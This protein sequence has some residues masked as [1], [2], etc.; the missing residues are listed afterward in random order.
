MN[1]ARHTVIEGDA[2]LRPV[3]KR[4]QPASVLP[5]AN[6]AGIFIP[7]IISRPKEAREGFKIGIFAGIHGGEEAGTLAV[8]ELT[9]WAETDPGELYDFE[10]HLYPVCNPSGF[11]TG[12]RNSRSG[13]DLNREFWSGSNEPEIVY[14]ENEL[15]REAY[16]VIVS[17]HADHD[18]EGVYG[19]VSGALL[20][21]EVLEPAL[22]AAS[23]FLPR[24]EWPTIDGFAS[25]RGIIKEGYSGVLSAPPE[26]RPRALEVV[27]ETPALAPMEQQVLAT[28]AAVKAILASYRELQAY[29]ANL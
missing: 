28:V 4:R 24:N 20:S 27:F 5:A 21:A 13:L 19:F 26:Q 2:A 3:T 15:V 6:P 1:T 14:L 29:A 17:L 8:F 25:E 23:A 7:K 11:L 22:E 12:D 9:R 18:S 16:D 10:L